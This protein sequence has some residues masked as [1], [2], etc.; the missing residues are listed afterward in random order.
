ME[1]RATLRISSQHI[2]NWLLHNIC[3]KEQVHTI[4]KRMAVIVDSQNLATPDYQM[5]SE[6]FEQSLAFEAATQLIFQ[7]GKQPS[8]YT[9]PLLHAYRRNYKQQTTLTTAI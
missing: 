6:D 7:A 9:E 8:G 5:M 4:L 3:S 1:D 2:Y